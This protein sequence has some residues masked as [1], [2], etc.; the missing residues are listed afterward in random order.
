MV[1]PRDG[2][3]AGAI[4]LRFLGAMFGGG[5]GEADRE[6]K[7]QGNEVKGGGQWCRCGMCMI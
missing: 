3:V 7:G 1:T 2:Q 5:G 4:Q 6:A